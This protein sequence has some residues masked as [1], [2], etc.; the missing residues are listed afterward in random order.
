MPGLQLGICTYGLSTFFQW[1]KNRELKG[2][3]TGYQSSC[4]QAI[5]NNSLTIGSCSSP[6][7]VQWSCEGSKLRLHNG[8]W[9]LTWNARKNVTEMKKTVNGLAGQW[10]L[11]ETDNNLCYLWPQTSTTTVP[12]TKPTTLP[13]AGQRNSGNYYIRID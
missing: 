3:Y 6:Y 11:Y 10:L 7:T 13:T 9:Y 1:T 4:I 2:V 8:M 12:F 5:P